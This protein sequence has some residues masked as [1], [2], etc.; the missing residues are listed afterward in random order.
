MTTERGGTFS[1]SGIPPHLRAAVSY[2]GLTRHTCR[3]RH[4]GRNLH[5]RCAI[6]RRFYKLDAVTVKGIREGTALAIQRQ[7][8]RPT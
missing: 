2:E 8:K 3:S 7:R 4:R 1:L 5:A 6:G